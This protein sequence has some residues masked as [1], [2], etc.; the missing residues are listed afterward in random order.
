MEPPP[1]CWPEVQV[2]LRMRRELGHSSPQDPRE[3]PA[4][5]LPVEIDERKPFFSQPT[6]ALPTTAACNE[7]AALSS[8]SGSASAN[9]SRLMVL[10]EK[11]L[12]VR[13]QLYPFPKG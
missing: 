7:K 2:T 6:S 13:A 5:E 11:I 3:Q 8:G 12:A 10:T 4:V 9:D 1:R